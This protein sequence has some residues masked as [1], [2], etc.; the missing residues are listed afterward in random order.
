MKKLE[1]NQMVN[2]FSGLGVAVSLACSLQAMAA[3]PITFDTPQ[4]QAESATTAIP[5][6]HRVTVHGADLLSMKSGESFSITIPGHDTPYEVIGDRVDGASP[7]LAPTWIGHLKGYKD[8]YRTTTPGFP[9]PP[10]TR[11]TSSP[12]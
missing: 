5:V 2:M 11:K 12:T 10:A 3:S 1:I 6:R 9:S 4:M 8:E 7:L